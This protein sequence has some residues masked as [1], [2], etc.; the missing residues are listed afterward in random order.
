M[1]RETGRTRAAHEEDRRGAEPARD[2]PGGEPAR[3]QPG[4]EPAEAGPE[5]PAPGPVRRTDTS[6]TRDTGDTPG[7]ADRAAPPD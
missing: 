7:P 1:T 3:N 6:G 4:G 5:R 2:Q